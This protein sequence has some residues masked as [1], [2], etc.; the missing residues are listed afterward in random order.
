MEKLVEGFKKFRLGVF[1]EKKELFRQLAQHQQPQALFITCSDSRLDPCM[2]T[3]TEPGDLFILRNAGNLVP[4]YGSNVGG[5]TATIEFALGVLGIR[6]VIVCGHT[7]CGVM[8]AILDP[9]QIANFPSVKEWLLQ[10]EATRQV[11]KENYGHLKG[12]EL[13]IATIQE[14]VR[15]QLT[16]L[17]THP[18]VAAKLRSGG[19]AL[20][21][22]VYSIPTGHMSAYDYKNDRFADLLELE[23]ARKK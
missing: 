18:I 4:S 6:D 20:H 7:D 3:Q 2:L 13:L 1:D 15:I 10:A 9:D 22:W 17:R 12:E 21:G 23:A 16:H 14:N 19:V 8:K 11:I 5:T